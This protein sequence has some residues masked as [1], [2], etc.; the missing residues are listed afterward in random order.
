MYSVHAM[1]FKDYQAGS[2]RKQFQFRSFLPEPINHEW[3]WSD[4]QIHTL[5]AEANRHLGELNAFSL[6]VPDVDRFIR[7]HVVKEA[8]TSS[9]IEGTQT[10]M[11][12]AAQEKPDAISPEKRDDWLEVRNYIAAMNH[13]LAKLERLPLSNRLLCETHGILLRAGRGKHRAPGNLRQSQNWIGGASLADAVFIP[14]SHEEVPELLSDLEKFWHNE[15]I[16]VPDLIRVAISH[17]QFETIHPFLDGNGRVGRLMITLYLVSRGLLREPSLYLSAH[18]EKHRADYYD[19]LTRV[20]TANDLAHWIRFFLVAVIETARTGVATFQAI[21]A[22]RAEMDAKA[23][24]MGRKAP[25]ARNLLAHL[26]Q[27]PFVTT[28]DVSAAMEISQATADRLI[29]DFVKAGILKEL[30]GYRRNRQFSFR[31]YFDL[32]RK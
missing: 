26:Y 19:A 24:A 30:T 13:A 28:S 5:L 6:I 9:R 25:R 4:P 3:T 1:D 27:H 15:T 12:E 23:E 32:F 17:Y 22:L 16:Q 20:R 10:E 11:E 29:A 7:M 14:P 8:Q 31:S 21:L 18:F 2:F